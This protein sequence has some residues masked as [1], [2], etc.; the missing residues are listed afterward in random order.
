MS[1]KQELARIAPDSSIAVY[2]KLLDSLT[3]IDKLG[4]WMCKSQMFGCDNLEQGK[5]LALA[6][7]IER[8][9]PIEITRK[10]HLIDGHLSMR[11]DAMQAHFQAD[12]GQITWIESTTEKCAAKLTHPKYG[13][14]TLTVTLQELKDN[15]VAM[16]KDGKQLKH[17]Y[18]RFPRQTLRAR[19]V[20]EG[21][22]MLAPGIVAGVYTPE[23]LPAPGEDASERPLFAQQATETPLAGNMRALEAVAESRQPEREVQPLPVSQPAPDAPAKTEAAPPVAMPKTTPEDAKAKVIDVLQPC[24]YGACSWMRDKHWLKEDQNLTHLRVD[25][26]ERILARPEDYTKLFAEYGKQKRMEQAQQAA[27]APKAGAV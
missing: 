14:A 3:A 4:E 13:N 7:I 23:E 6:C 24:V 26:C 10:Y 17:N 1:D 25:Q 16:T 12:G 15:G 18:A 20:S 5:M 27:D 2:D 11:A 9:S 8:K 21:V 19:V 22:R